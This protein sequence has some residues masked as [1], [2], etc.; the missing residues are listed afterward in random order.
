MV[1]RF[2]IPAALL[3]L[4][5]VLSAC[6]SRGEVEAGR[7]A[8]EEAFKAE[9]DAKCRSADMTPGEPAYE[10]C[11]QDLAAKRAQKAEIDYQKARD[12]DRVLGGLN[13]L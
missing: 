11:R 12:F 5:L 13:D 7:L 10:A 1:R 6:A 4:A 8:K 2:F 9:D 3:S